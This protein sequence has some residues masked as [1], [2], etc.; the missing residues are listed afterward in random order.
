MLNA[1]YQESTMMTE[2]QSWQS[3]P[4]GPPILLSEVIKHP[5]VKSG[6]EEVS[7]H[8][9]EV[10]K[11]AGNSASWRRCNSWYPVTPWNSWAGK[12]SNC[13]QPE[14][15]TPHELAQS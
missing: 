1:F 6:S 13:S 10:R 15:D 9:H 3:G 7:H 8:W 4:R 5:T 11:S 14:K 12:Q 2:S